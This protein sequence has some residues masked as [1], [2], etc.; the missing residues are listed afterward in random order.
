MKNYKTFKKQLLKDN[1]IKKAYNELGPEFTLV[2]KLI[3]K[4]LKQG[5]TQQ[6]LAKRVGTKQPVISRFESGTYNPTIKFLHRVTDALGAEL[7]VSVS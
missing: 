1:S 4:R 6:E 7:H 3:E 5:W 2:E